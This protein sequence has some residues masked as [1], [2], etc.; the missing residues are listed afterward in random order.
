MLVIVERIERPE[1]P[2]DRRDSRDTYRAQEAVEL[3]RI[4]DALTLLALE[5]PAASQGLMG[6]RRAAT[7]AVYSRIIE[8]EQT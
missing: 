1:E 2:S 5:G 6:D 4:A 8:R 3:K 7:E